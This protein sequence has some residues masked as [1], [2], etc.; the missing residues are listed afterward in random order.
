MLITKTVSPPQAIQDISHKDVT[1]WFG[2]DVRIKVEA[3][4]SKTSAN[5]SPVLE[6]GGGKNENRDLTYSMLF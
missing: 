3:H 1:Y 6:G 5:F 2:E 4:P